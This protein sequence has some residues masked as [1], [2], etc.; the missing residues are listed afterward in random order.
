MGQKQKMERVK[1]R[2]K[3]GNNNGQLRIANATLGGTRK[4][5]WAKSL[6][7]IFGQCSVVDAW[8]NPSPLEYSVC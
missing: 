4:A 5:G 7:N 3:E 2:L 8:T 6:A 1:E